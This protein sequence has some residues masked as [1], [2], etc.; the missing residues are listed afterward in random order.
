MSMAK[1]VKKKVKLISIVA[2]ICIAITLL[3]VSCNKIN[4]IEINKNHK[5]INVV[6]VEIKTKSVNDERNMTIDIDFKIKKRV[7]K[8]NVS[9]FILKLNGDAVEVEIYNSQGIKY[10]ESSE[11]SNQGE[12]MSVAIKPIMFELN[13]AGS[14]SVE[15]SYNGTKLLW[16][17]R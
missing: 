2:V 14:Y 4:G 3:A 13:S 1:K 17:S 15:L 12:E 9:L 5:E 16:Y 6:G 11:I 7:D 10:Q 8:L